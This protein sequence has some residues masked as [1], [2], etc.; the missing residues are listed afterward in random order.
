M[1]IG[2]SS[3]IADIETGVVENDLAACLGIAGFDPFPTHCSATVGVVLDNEA[4]EV[5]QT[6]QKDAGTDV[7]TAAC[8]GGDSQ[9]YSALGPV[10]GLRAVAAVIRR[11]GTAGVDGRSRA[12]IRVTGASGIA[13]ARGQGENH[14]QSNQERKQFLHHHFFLSS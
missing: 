5:A 3:D 2:E 7:S 4:A 8:A 13:A 6:L 1:N 14:C 12:F 11:A 10:G 9:G